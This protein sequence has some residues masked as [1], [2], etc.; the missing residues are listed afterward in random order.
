MNKILLVFCL[1]LNSCTTVT[2]EI[3]YKTFKICSLACGAGNLKSVKSEIK[4]F[5][6]TMN[7]KIQREICQCSDRAQVFLEY[8]GKIKKTLDKEEKQELGDWG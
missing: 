8:E 6:N 1:L 2:P 5:L 7:Q 3:S 4:V